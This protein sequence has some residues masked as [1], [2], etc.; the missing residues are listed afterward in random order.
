MGLVRNG[1]ETHGEDKVLREENGDSG[2]EAKQKEN[3]LEYPGIGFYPFYVSRTDCPADDDPRSSG[4]GVHNNPKD[5]VEVRGN[6]I[7][8]ENF[9]PHVSQDRNLNRP[10]NSPKDIPQNNRSTVFDEIPQKHLIP[11]L[12]IR[13]AEGEDLVV[14]ANVNERNG[15]FGKTGDQSRD[16]RPVYAQRRETEFSKN[17]GKAQEDVNDKTGN[18]AKEPYVGFLHATHGR[19]QDAVDTDENVGKANHREVFHSFGNDKFI[20]G[21]DTQ[22]IFGEKSYRQGQEGPHDKSDLNRYGDDNLGLFYI[23]LPDVLGSQN[24]QRGA[25]ARTEHRQDPLDLV[26]NKDPRKS[27]IPQGADHKII[28][29]RYTERDEALQSQGQG[30]CCQGTVKRTIDGYAVIGHEDISI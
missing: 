18:G 23:A 28:R 24:H 27:H 9:R 3:S 10:A 19:E 16:C 30:D 2:D 7:G 22:D 20:S 29:K 5:I 26:G 21:K 6:G 12:E 15:E 8:R 25:E 4:N 13:Q 14:K 11:E 17:E 1:M